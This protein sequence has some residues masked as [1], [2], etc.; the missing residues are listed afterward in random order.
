MPTLYYSDSTGTKK[1][2]PV[3]AHAHTLDRTNFTNVAASADGS[4]TDPKEGQGLYWIGNPPDDA[5][6]GK[7]YAGDAPVRAPVSE[8]VLVNWFEPVSWNPP[9]PGNPDNPD[10][11]A[12]TWRPIDPV[13]SIPG[14][15]FSW[16][17]P[18]SFGV[19]SE[20][21]DGY[22][23]LQTTS[24]ITVEWGREVG[25]GA[26][27]MPYTS[28]G[29]RAVGEY[30]YKIT[31]LCQ[32]LNTKTGAVGP[33]KVSLGMAFYT[34]NV[35]RDA[36]NAPQ[37]CASKHIVWGAN[38]ID[39]TANEDTDTWVAVECY[40]NGRVEPTDVPT[41]APVGTA[42]DWADQDPDAPEDGYFF[43]PV[44]KVTGANADVIIDSIQV[45]RG[46]RNLTVP[47]GIAT[48]SVNAQ[49][50]IAEEQ[51]V[52][53]ELALTPYIGSRP[54]L[55]AT[56]VTEVS[57]VD[58]LS[59]W[60]RVPYGLGFAFP[61]EIPT[62]ESGGL[63]FTWNPT[64]DQAG[65]TAK[66]STEQTFTFR[67]NLT[68]RFTALVTPSSL[69]AAPYAVGVGFLVAG[70]P[71][72]APILADDPENPGTTLPDE[73]VWEWTPTEDHVDEP[74]T[75]A[76]VQADENWANAGTHTLNYL[77]VEEIGERPG[78]IDGLGDPLDAS[79]PVTKGWLEAQD[80]GETGSATVIH[81]PDAT[82]PE[83]PEPE[84]GPYPDGTIWVNPSAIQ[85]PPTFF[86]HVLY[87]GSAITIPDGVSYTEVPNVNRMEFTAPGPG[88]LEITG[89][90]QTNAADYYCS[91]R[92]WRLDGGGHSYFSDRGAVL[93]LD[94]SGQISTGPTTITIDA[95]VHP[96]A[97]IGFD[98]PGTSVFVL[99][100]SKAAGTRG[101]TISWAG[102]FCRWTPGAHVYE[103]GEHHPG[104]STAAYTL[105][106]VVRVRSGD[107]WLPD[108]GL[109][110]PGRQSL[111]PG[112]TEVNVS[113]STSISGGGTQNGGSRTLTA[114]VTSGSGTPVGSVQFRSGSTS[115]TVIATKT[116]SGGT[117]T[118]SVSSSGTYYVTYQGGKSGANNYQ[119][120]NSGGTSV[121]IR[122]LKTNTV[123]RGRNWNGQYP[124]SNG[125]QQSDYY[126]HHW[127]QGRYSGTWGN[128]KTLL[129]FT[130]V[131]GVS[132]LD[133]VTK[134]V[135]KLEIDHTYYGSGVDLDI[136]WHTKSNRPS[137][138]GVGNG[139]QNNQGFNRSTGTRTMELGS[140]AR[141]AVARSD[142][143][144]IVIGSNNSGNY[145]HYGYGTGTT[146]L[147]ITYKYWA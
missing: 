29:D 51:V 94:F 127:R 9:S 112:I 72:Q 104:G 98:G 48:T 8:T 71:T 118:H 131:G 3:A 142:F 143:G 13:S 70:S 145:N 15:A 2:A 90:V 99:E 32:A 63:L 138:F 62:V 56:V 101:G 60:F 50:I 39:L 93:D 84:E 1:V 21:V 128:W 125:Y 53:H 6:P 58:G 123:T 110:L 55:P 11:A 76:V 30:T 43:A 103:S 108:T 7:W 80:T 91:Y 16:E 140:W 121:T 61:Q 77:Q 122:S 88:V 135:L 28:A 106:P 100:A 78:R 89:H 129:G 95:M 54:Q 119:P 146:Q 64:P 144:G 116:L 69:S 52:A 26:R 111:D 35:I 10:G 85:Q 73:L 136:G 49:Q 92:V 41:D 114:T 5:N 44:I 120:S 67:A 81:V 22:I 57:E 109:A 59:A 117:A 66:I 47:G 124:E 130:G 31:A 74:L 37:P 83:P 82:N 19:A 141:T 137:S 132:N 33:W 40:M 134:V 96:R 75:F 115:G 34:N 42:K 46:N 68:Y 20:T 18:G 147:E 126:S 113:T 139:S 105:A 133:S 102:F 86:W 107:T 79:D 97:F 12:G 38:E 24:D 36:S 4:V 23:R 65:D 27:P 14:N 87:S 17:D 45:L 25:S